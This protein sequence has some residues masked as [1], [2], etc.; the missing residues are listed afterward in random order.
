[1]VKLQK[2]DYAAL[3]ESSTKVVDFAKSRD[4]F[5][6]KDVMSFTEPFILDIC[7]VRPVGFHSK[8]IIFGSVLIM[9]YVSW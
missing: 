5:S 1:M 6:M 9:F 8:L 4:S 7:K 3:E 2:A